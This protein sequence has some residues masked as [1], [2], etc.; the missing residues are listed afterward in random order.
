VSFVNYNVGVL[1]RRVIGARFAVCAKFIGVG[2]QSHNYCCAVCVGARESA[3]L[4]LRS[5][6]VNR[7]KIILAADILLVL[8]DIGV[9]GCV[10]GFHWFDFS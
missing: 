1:P 8:A 4:S 3:S 10:R 2:D 6:D 9:I 7:L 5:I